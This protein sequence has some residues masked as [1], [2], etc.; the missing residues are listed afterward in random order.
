MMVAHRQLLSEA[1]AV[2][3]LNGNKSLNSTKLDG[4]S[5]CDDRGMNGK[6]Q[7]LARTHI[8]C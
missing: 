5:N 6:Q 3:A 1:R 7:I 8:H 2:T 4:H